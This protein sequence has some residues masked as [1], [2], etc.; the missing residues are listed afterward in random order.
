[1]A[2]GSQC[3][4]VIQKEKWFPR[5]SNTGFEVVCLNACKL[6]HVILHFRCLQGRPGILNHISVT[7][8]EPTL[9][10]RSNQS[11]W[12]RTHDVRMPE[13]ENKSPYGI[14]ERC[15]AWVGYYCAKLTV[16]GAN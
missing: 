1:M 4:L 7:F 11:L 14:L 10:W 12:C 13:R 2:Y 6:A 9:L 3:G 16:C 8:R 15:G 5:G